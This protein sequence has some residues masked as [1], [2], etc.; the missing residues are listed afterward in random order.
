[1]VNLNEAF[2]FG[3]VLIYIAM[4]LA[5][6]LYD[7]QLYKKIIIFVTFYF[8]FSC[9]N[10]SNRLYSGLSLFLESAYESL[11]LLLISKHP[12]KYFLFTKRPHF[13]LKMELSNS[14]SF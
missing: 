13:F 3:C 7:V 6:I 12:Y 2:F 5:Y 9:V 4:L 14:I 1:M 8:N 11:F 10:S